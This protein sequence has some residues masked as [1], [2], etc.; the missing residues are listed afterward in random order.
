MRSALYTGEIMHKRVRPFRHRFTTRV[1]ALYLDVDEVPALARRL[2]LFAHNRANIF[3]FRDADHGAKDGTPPRAWAE[4]HLARAGIDLDGG[5]IG[6]LCFPRMWGYVFNPLSVWFC[7]HAGGGLRAVIYAVN[8]TFGDRHA[9]LIPTRGHRPGEPIRQ[10]CDK[11]FHVSPFMP[12]RGQYGFRLHEPGERLTLAIHYTIDEQAMLVAT[13]TGTREPL[14][15]RA[16][17]RALVR[18]PA[19]THKVM[20]AI[21]WQALHLW[22]KGATF[23]SRPAPPADPVSVLPSRVEP[24][25]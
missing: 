24:R 5:H 2:R 9:Y 10:R 14:T 20:G 8:N 13:Q 4:D 12:V 3:S 19:M 25:E 15:D 18:Y 7:Y 17:L 16:L 21:H 23:H 22:R 6:L 1:A 11:V